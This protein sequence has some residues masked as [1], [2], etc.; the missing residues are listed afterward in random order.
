VGRRRRGREFALKVLYRIELTGEEWDSIRERLEEYEAADS[1]RSF[2]SF[3]VETVLANRAALDQIIVTVAENWRI[4]RMATI[5]RNVLRV[6]LAE[7]LVIGQT[8]AAV[9]I[10]EAVEIAGTFSTGESGR[11]VNGILDRI[12]RE[13]TPGSL[14]PSPPAG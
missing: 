8:P 4:E 3:L 12:V 10:D 11:F 1:V 5:D 9:I 14:S 7:Y 13:H 6:A 2:G